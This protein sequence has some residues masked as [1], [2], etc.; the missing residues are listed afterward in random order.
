M[1]EREIGREQEP[2]PRITTGI[3]Q[4]RA[5]RYPLERDENGRVKPAGGEPVF[6]IKE[7]SFPYTR[8]GWKDLTRRLVDQL[9][10]AEREYF[11]VENVSSVSLG[12][13]A[14]L[15]DH[16]DS[17]TIRLIPKDEYQEAYAQRYGDAIYIPTFW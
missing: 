1:S 10:G 8:E 3:F 15:T 4:L 14:D 5:E 9:E 13:W 7:V 12:P 17:D 2:Q 16:M 6:A 11:D